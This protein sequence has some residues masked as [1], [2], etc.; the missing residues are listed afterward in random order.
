MGIGDIIAAV[1][2]VIGMLIAYPALLIVLNMLFNRTTTRVAERLDGGM[3]SSFVVG[4]IV[5]G[6]GGVGIFVLLSAGSVLQ[7]IGFIL[8]LLLSFWGTVGNAALIRVFGQRLATMDDRQPSPLTKLLWGGFALTLSFAFPLIGWFVLMPIISVM[9][10]GA[11][12]LNLFGRAKHD[13]ASDA[14]IV[15]DETMVT[16]Q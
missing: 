7:L 15:S 12:T 14:P 13:R 3:K 2:I 6:V 10:I 5:V 8:Y 4:A 16:A 9:T 11:M 1:S